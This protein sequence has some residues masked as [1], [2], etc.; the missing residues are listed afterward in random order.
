M[1]QTDQMSGKNTVGKLPERQSMSNGV[2]ESEDLADLFAR[3]QSGERHRSVCAEREDNCVEHRPHHPAQSTSGTVRPKGY[4]NLARA[5]HGKNAKPIPKAQMIA[6]SIGA[7]MLLSYAGVKFVEKIS[8]AFGDVSSTVNG[9]VSGTTERGGLIHPG[10]LIHPGTMSL[11]T[12]QFGSNINSSQEM[13][14][15][16]SSLP[17]A[18]APG[19]ALP[20]ALPHGFS[21]QRPRHKHPH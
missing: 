10:S 11:H 1:P 20:P 18:N 7:L 14:G 12:S 3:V 4:K 2:Q 17:G 8:V 19:Y 13:P 9:T 16:H 21:L 5:S 15:F 6:V